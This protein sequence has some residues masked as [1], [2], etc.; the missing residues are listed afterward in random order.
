MLE[1]AKDAKGAKKKMKKTVGFMTHAEVGEF[2]L[3]SPPTPSLS[4]KERGKLG[5]HFGNVMM[6]FWIGALA[7]RRISK[8]VREMLR[9]CR[10][11]SITGS[12]S[13][14]NLG[15]ALGN[16]TSRRDGMPLARK[17]ICGNECLTES[18]FPS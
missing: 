16:R 8:V 10:S 13:S 11:L 1:T 6:L 2:P 18:K 17:F 12:I 5:L 14:A 4:A 3:N 7:E 9:H 15:A